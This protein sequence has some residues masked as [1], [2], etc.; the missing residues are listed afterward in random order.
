MDT[1]Y[2]GFDPAT[3]TFARPSESPTAGE[4][5]EPARAVP[6]YPAPKPRTSVEMP[7]GSIH[8]PSGMKAPLPEHL[9]CKAISRQQGDRC[10]RP[11][12]PGAS[13]CAKHGGNLPTVRRSAQIRL[14]EL[15]NPAIATLAR[16]LVKAERSADRIRAA[17]SLLD[18][19][20]VGREGPDAQAARALLIE[21]LLTMRDGDLPQLEAEVIE[22]ADELDDDDD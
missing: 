20:G 6:R 15:V 11:A 9:R 19:A 8:Y 3:V 4:P 7:D 18:R 13:V 16:E 22:D 17:N 2:A 1:P 21:R 12:K 14:A 10:R 5:P